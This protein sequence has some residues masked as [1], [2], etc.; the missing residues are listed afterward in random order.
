MVGATGFELDRWWMLVGDDG[1][2]IRQQPADR[3]NRAARG[4]GYV[5]PC[6][7]IVQGHVFH[8]LTQRGASRHLFVDLLLGDPVVIVT[9]QDGDAARAAVIV[10]LGL[11]VHRLQQ[12]TGRRGCGGRGWW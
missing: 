3:Q 11:V 4:W 1:N 9:E 8:D 7:Q 2:V 6:H 5:C 10:G 12:H